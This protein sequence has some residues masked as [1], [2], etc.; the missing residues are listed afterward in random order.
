MLKPVLMN[1][2][3]PHPA[4]ASTK[5]TRLWAYD[6]S[7][8]RAHL[9]AMLVVLSKDLVTN[10][11][12]IRQTLGPLHRAT[13]D[14]ISQLSA[15][16]ANAVDGEHPSSSHLDVSM[17]NG[18]VRYSGKQRA[19]R[20]WELSETLRPIVRADYVS[21]AQRVTL[22][23]LLDQIGHLAYELNGIKRFASDRPCNN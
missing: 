8:D 17:H 3:T 16:I 13:A 1:T 4:M 14:W 15:D 19:H 18:G 10:L 23:R 9:D 20:I 7:M 12:A 5:N 11:G 2:V 6:E 22:T 21:P